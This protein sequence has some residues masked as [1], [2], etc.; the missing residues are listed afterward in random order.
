M[1]K[2]RVMEDV[3][4]YND[5]LAMIKSIH[6]EQA[7]AYDKF[8]ME[9]FL[10]RGYTL[11]MLKDSDTSIIERSGRDGDETIYTYIVDNVP[12]LTMRKRTTLI[13]DTEHYTT[14]K[15]KFEFDVLEGEN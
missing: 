3:N 5:I 7:D 9:E 14:Y 15:V 12:V 1:Y 11:D 4:M 10:K 2:C 6:N 8:L 13:S